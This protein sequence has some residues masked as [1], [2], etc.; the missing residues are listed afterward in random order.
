M[1]LGRKEIFTDVQEITKDNIISVLRDA[2]TVHEANANRI[3]FLLKY[4]AGNQPITREKKYRSDINCIVNDNI[5]AEITDFKT[6][7]MW[8]DPITFVQKGVSDGGSSTEIEAIG[9][10]NACYDAENIKAKTQKNGRFVEIGGLG[11]SYTDINTEYEKGDSFFKYEILDPRYTF[12]IKSGYYIDHRPM[13]GV[14][15]RKDQKTGNKYYTC[16]TKNERFEIVDALKIVNGKPTDKHAWSH[17]NRSGESNPLGRIPI[18]EWVRNYDLLGA[19]ER[20][21]SEMDNVNLLISDLSNDIEQNTMA[22]WHANDVEFPKDENGNTLQPSTNDWLQTFTTTDGKTPFVTPL[23]VQYDYN[24]ILQNINTRRATILQKCHIPVR[25]DNSGGSTG[26]AMDSATGWNDAENIANMQQ[27]IMECCRMEEVKLAL[28]AISKSQDVPMDNPLKTLEVTDIQPSVKRSKQY[29]LNSKINAFAT[30]VSH[31]IYGEHMLKLINAFPDVNQVWEDSK[32][33]ITKYQE[34]MFGD[35]Q[36]SETPQIKDRL[37][38]DESD[39]VEN[40][41]FL[42]G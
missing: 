15:Y 41:P 9:L 2:V 31:G 37:Q 22:I 36:T 23:A 38:Q 3:D 10:L 32:E 25:N 13:V 14:T 39:Q 19:W 18:V 33:G 29:E 21:I 17:R 28:I 8:S 26:V 24:G 4:E 11:Y 34:K 27:S 6:G 20:Q 30:G 1:Q 40:S 12:I 5:A 42:E 16:F 7:F 35:E